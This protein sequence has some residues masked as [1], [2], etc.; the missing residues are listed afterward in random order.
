MEVDNFGGY[1]MAYTINGCETSDT[2]MVQFAQAIPQ[3]NI[4]ELIYCDFEALLEVES[5]GMEEGWGFVDGPSDPVFTDPMSFETSL[6]VSD[7]GDYSLIYTGCDTSVSFNVLFM[8]D[9]DPPN[10]FSPNGDGYNDYFIIED[11]T[12][13][14]YSYSNMS[15]Y[16]R[17]GDE[18]YKNGYY[19]LDGSWWDGKN[20]HEYD[21]LARGVYLSL[22]HI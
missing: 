5:F 18:I 22:I 7:Y 21:Q 20:T 19:G 14:Y 6:V 1:Q 9:L 12:T 11:L 10:T 17:W 16:N 3:L 2:L 4:E 13:E 8:C 15:I